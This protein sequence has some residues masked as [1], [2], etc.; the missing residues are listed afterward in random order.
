MA[1]AARTW[2]IGSVVLLGVGLSAGVVGLL[3]Y[4]RRQATAPAVT[5]TEGEAC[6]HGSWAVV[7]RDGERR[8]CLSLDA[9][10][11]ILRLY[12]PQADKE[13]AEERP[14]SAA[15]DYECAPRAAASIEWPG[16]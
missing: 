6:E 5:V 12:A 16:L 9:A 2:V 11:E 13:G 1:D 3:G 15:F 7:I 4:E 10:R 14:A 8:S